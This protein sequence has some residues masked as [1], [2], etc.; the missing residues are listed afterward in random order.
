M[1][2]ETSTSPIVSSSEAQAPIV[3]ALD[4]GTSSVRAALYDAAGRE[5]AGAESRVSRTLTATAGGGSEIDAEAAFSQ[6]VQAIDDLMGK[7]GAG[8]FEIVATG[9]SCL[10][11]ILV[12]IDRDGRAVT[13]VYGWADTRAAEQADRLRQREDA[14]EVYL[15]TGARFH[16]S[17]WPAKLLWLRE[18]L[19]NSVFQSARWLSFSDY[20]FLRLCG[21]LSTSVSMASGTGLLDRF[22]CRWDQPLLQSLELSVDALPPIND[23]GES[24]YTLSLEYGERWPALKSTRWVEAIG[25]GAANNVGAGCVNRDSLALMIGTSGAMR[26]MIEGAPPEELKAGL[27]CYRLDRGR[28]IVGGAL[29]DGG[30]LFAWMVNN[31]RTG[32]DAMALEHELATLA[33]DGHGLTLMPFW[34]GERS[35]GWHDNARGAILGLTL[36]TRPVE[37]VR[38]AMESVAYRFAMI[39]EALQQ[40]APRAEVVASGGALTASHVWTQI[41]ADVFGRPLTLT[42][43][44]EA[45]SRGAALFALEAV[46]AIRSIDSALQGE[47]MVFNPNMENHDRYRAALSRQQALYE[48]LVADSEIAALISG[49]NPGA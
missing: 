37:I 33:P 4:I 20:L 14:N 29:S 42:I 16:P 31:L 32:G 26:L 28:P 44:H 30:G 19:P 43:A 21:R 38:A 17:Y 27:W 2:V 5:I 23:E 36:H 47:G 11:H 6:V 12:G 39:F 49:V 35:T 25:D 1:A 9:V 15:R 3:L 41:L 46:G 45:S 34:A 18:R 40:V 13:P 48:T 7:E 10:W 22:A 24:F 8:R